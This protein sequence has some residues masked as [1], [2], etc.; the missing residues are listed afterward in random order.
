MANGTNTEITLTT[1]NGVHTTPWEAKLVVTQNYNT[2]TNKSDVYVAMYVRSSVGSIATIFPYGRIKVNG[3]DVGIYYEQSVTANGTSWIEVPGTGSISIPHDAN[4][5]ATITVSV[6]KY[7]SSYTKFVFWSSQSNANFQVNL[8]NYSVALQNIPRESKITS[9]SNVTI[10]SACNVKWTP[11][12]STYSFVLQFKLGSI[13]K[14]SPVISPNTT[15]EYTYTGYSIPQDIAKAIPNSASG[16][17]TISLYTYSDS[18]AKTQ[19]G[20]VSSTTVTASC[21]STMVPTISN[22]TAVIN[23]SNSVVKSWGIAVAGYTNVVFSASGSGVQGSTITKYNITGGY[24]KMIQSTGNLSH[25]SSVITSSGNKTFTVTCT[26]SRGRVS[27]PVTTTA[28]NFYPYSAPSISSFSAERVSGSTTQVS[29]IGSWTYASVNNKN[30]VTASVSIKQANSTAYQANTTLTN[31][32]KKTLSGTF[33]IDKSYTIKLTVTDKLSQTSSYEVTVSTESVL[34]DFKSGGKGFG[35]GKICETNSFE[36]GLPA[37]FFS[38]ITIRVGGTD[39]TL[40]N[41]IKGVM[42]GTYK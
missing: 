5:D 39:V 38:S 31:N 32:T 20:S 13:T 21:P 14:T 17:M 29:A 12:V 2:E 24:T 33:D 4:G 9:A 3:N 41:Y 30:S 27:A 10:G 16:S 34:L 36:V 40:A 1:Q 8:G 19:I 35:I 23:N 25:T 18:T 22:V 7:N 15:S 28:I 26:D 42:D 37:K 11:N 6:D